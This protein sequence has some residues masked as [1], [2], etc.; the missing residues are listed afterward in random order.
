MW[1]KTLPLMETDM[2]ILTYTNSDGRAFVRIIPTIKFGKEFVERVT[3]DAIAN[4]EVMT[5]ISTKYQL[6]DWDTG[7]S[8]TITPQVIHHDLDLM[9]ADFDTFAVEDDEG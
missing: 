1:D 5:D 4:Y 6:V 7:E 8:F 3:G 9:V 2:F